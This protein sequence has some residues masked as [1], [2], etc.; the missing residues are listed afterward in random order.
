MKARTWRDAA[1]R[2]ALAARQA[3]RDRRQRTRGLCVLTGA[4]IA[5]CR[6]QPMLTAEIMEAVRRVIH[7]EKE[8]R[9]A[10]DL[11]PPIA[12]LDEM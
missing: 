5:A 8:Q 4:I 10:L 6:R 12:W 2:D 3:E 9:L 7:D 1:R 11:L